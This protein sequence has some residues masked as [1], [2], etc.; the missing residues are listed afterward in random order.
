ML[1]VHIK[2]VIILGI[3]LQNKKFL[4]I[5][6]IHVGE[7]YMYIERYEAEINIWHEFFL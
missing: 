7:S 2:G 6:T 3:G 5:L 4:Q 1:Y